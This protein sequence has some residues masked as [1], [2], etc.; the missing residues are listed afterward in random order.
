MLVDALRCS[1]AILQ[2]TLRTVKIARDKTMSHTIVNSTTFTL[3]QAAKEI[4]LAKSTV[5]SAI[6][7][8][9]LSASKIDGVF[10]I[11]AAELYRA[12][13]KGGLKK[14][15]VSAG[16]ALTQ[17]AVLEVKLEAS[18]KEITSL[19]SQ[20]SDAL[21]ERDIRRGELEKEQAKNTQLVL[22]FE[23]DKEANLAAKPEPKKSTF[24][25]WILAL[26]VLA[27]SAILADRFGLISLLEL[28]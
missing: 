18:E 27:L 22:G 19:K 7:S 20:L 1:G 11:Q 26:I 12:W 17:Q 9:K 21:N 15:P 10:Q 16:E 3:G 23:R 25:L 8:G 6:K 24:T 14:E 5:Y 2:R 28:L 13:P 4:G